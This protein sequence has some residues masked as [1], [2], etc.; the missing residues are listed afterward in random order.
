MIHVLG[1]QDQCQH[2]LDLL[3]RNDS[4]TRGPESMSTQCTEY[5]NGKGF[6]TS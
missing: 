1:V 6:N 3:H 2:K 5:E 4:L